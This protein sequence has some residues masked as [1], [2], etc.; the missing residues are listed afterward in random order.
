M[1]HW[2]IIN[3]E[4]IN[5]NP[6]VL[7]KVLT[8]HWCLKR[9]ATFELVIYHLD[10][11]KSMVANGPKQEMTVRGSKYLSVRL[12]KQCLPATTFTDWAKEQHDESERRRKEKFL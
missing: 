5:V 11:S 6:T 10:K 4:Q 9:N 8:C 2:E 7:N 3:M 1:T 12:C